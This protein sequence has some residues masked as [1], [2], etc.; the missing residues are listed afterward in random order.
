MPGLGGAPA[1]DLIIR[2]RVRAHPYFRREGLDLFLR[3]PLTLDEAYAGASVEVPTP[4]GTVKLNVPPRSQSGKK[5]RLREK[6][7]E[8]DG[9]RGNLYVELDVR[10]P[11]REDEQLGEALRRSS[12]LY[13][14]PVRDGIRL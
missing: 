1:G 5:L 12:E 14:Q 8:R 11:D 6:G 3:L 9:K 7:V 4:H 13:S 2:T 10:L